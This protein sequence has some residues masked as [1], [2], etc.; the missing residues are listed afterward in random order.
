[1]N[2]PTAE[3]L[4]AVEATTGEEVVLL[5]NNANVILAAEQAAQL[6]A[7][8][9]R[10]VPA[11]S[12]QAGLAALI[13]FNQDRPADE[14]AAEMSRALEE[15]STGEVAVA[16][17]DATFDGVTIRRGEFL[18]LVGR[19]R[20]RCRPCLST[21]SRV[22]SRSTCSPSRATC[23]RSSPE[24]TPRRSTAWSTAGRAAPGAGD[25]GARGRTAALSAAPVRRIESA[26]E[27][28]RSA[29]SWSRTTMSSARR[30]SCCSVCAARS[31]SSASVARR[32]RRGAGRRGA[33]ARRRR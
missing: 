5:P 4:A 27:R 28:S 26:Y 13:A 3:L 22:R 10:V 31:T 32:R 24:R 20:R 8:P 19:A 6:A 12:L 21:R 14:N 15:S 16:S 23:S 29:S 18:G 9:A 11:R 7:R 25:R 1:M 30:S 33:A 2:P 17:R